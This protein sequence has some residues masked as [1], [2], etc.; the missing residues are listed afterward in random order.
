M[1]VTLL[2]GVAAPVSLDPLGWL[3]KQEVRRALVQGCP[4]LQVM[5]CAFKPN[6]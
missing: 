6:S 3:V 2:T 5:P 1:G 4:Q